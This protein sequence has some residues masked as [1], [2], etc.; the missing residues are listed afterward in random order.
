MA[1]KTLKE[2]KLKGS[3]VL[4]RVDFNVPISYHGEIAD[5]TRI[6]SALPSI[7]HITGSEASLVLMSHMGRPDGRRDSS[8]S[9][10]VAAHKLGELTDYPVKFVDDCVGE[11]VEKMVSGLQPGEILLLENLR[12]YPGEKDN[13]PGFASRL[14]KWGDI[15]VNDAFGT[16]HRAHA[17]TVGVPILF[18]RKGAGFLLEKELRILGSLLEDPERPFVA[19]LGG[20]KI[21]SKVKLIENLAGLVDRVIIGG[22]MAFTFFKAAGLETGDSIV[23]DDYLRMCRELMETR[24]EQG[25]KKILLPVD[26]VVAEDT[27]GYSEFRT[28]SSGDIPEG[29]VG[30]DIGEKSIEMFAGELSGAGTIFWNGPMGIFENEDFAEGTRAVAGAIAESGARTVVGGGD[31]VSALNSIHLAGSIDH[32]STGG[33]ASLTLLEGSVL[34]AV[35]ALEG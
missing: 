1:W 35:S 4:M 26:V 25:I 3:R 24:D 28:V 27:D 32:I 5:D 15:Y 11:K 18:E 9:L 12:F 34:P 19:V 13:D 8:L 31:S 29:W 33:G 16:A 7:E 20:V 10:E 22:A 2:L 23:N 6:R 21:S 17:S 30:V 14:A